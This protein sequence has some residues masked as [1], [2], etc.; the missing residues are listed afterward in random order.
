M[1]ADDCLQCPRWTAIA[2]VPPDKLDEVMDQLNSDDVDALVQVGTNLPM[3]R[4]AMT[5]E[6]RL[7][8]PTIAINTATYWHALRNNGIDDKVAGFG[9]LLAEL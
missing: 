8:K 5:M 3:A 6:E 2:E 1:V 9:K 7:G 4:L